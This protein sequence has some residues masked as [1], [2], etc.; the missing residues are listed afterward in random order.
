MSVASFRTYM[1]LL[2]GALGYHNFHWGRTV[3]QK[4]ENIDPAIDNVLQTGR[5]CPEAV[6]LLQ[7]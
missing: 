6:A 5:Q 2:I 3:Y 7:S 1:Y 4:T